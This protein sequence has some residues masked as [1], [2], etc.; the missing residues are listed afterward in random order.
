LTLQNLILHHSERCSWVMFVGH[1]TE[2]GVLARQDPCEQAVEF[3]IRN[4]D[5]NKSTNSRESVRDRSPDT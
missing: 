2:K 4:A 5:G 1:R 3:L